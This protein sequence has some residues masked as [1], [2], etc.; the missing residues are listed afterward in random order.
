MMLT[1][2]D[3]KKELIEEI[4]KDKRANSLFNT[5]SS[6]LGTY[7][8][9]SEYAIRIG[10]CLG[11]VLRRYAPYESI[12][13][14]D[15]ENLIPQA[16]GLDHNYVA[17]ACRQVQQVLNSDAGLGINFQEPEFD[18]DRAYGMVAELR[19]H[20]NFV[21]IERT[22]YDQLVN[23]SQNVVDESI[24]RNAEVLYNS[25]LTSMVI[26]SNEFKACD[27]CKEVSGRYDYEE[28]KDKGNDV[29][30]RHENCRCTIDFVTSRNGS[31]YRERVNNQVRIS[32]DR[33]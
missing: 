9:A 11:R 8:T 30:R 20:P 12:Q 22:F 26:R 6:G 7:N 19:E 28:V 13:E 1:Y 15:L 2:E 33:R 25:G 10:T 23:F 5:I 27:W 29:W 32:S 18:F 24:R 3:I 14:W 4:A 31:S 17:Y 16:L 21:S